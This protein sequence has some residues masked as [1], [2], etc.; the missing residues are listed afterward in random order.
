M[1]S[2]AYVWRRVDVDGLVFVRLDHDDSSVSVEGSEICVE[3][4][5]EWSARFA[6]TLDGAWRHRRT[7][8]EVI[9]GDGT[10]QIELKSD[11]RGQWTRDGRPDPT[12]AGCT[13]VDLGGNPFTN[14]FVTRRV[15]PAVGTDVEVRAAFVET[16]GLSVRPVVQRYQRLAVDRWAYSD[17]EFGR[18][19][20]ETDADGIAVH[21]EGLAERLGPRPSS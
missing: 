6:I 9:D 20:L 7:M 13:D 17:D 2:A 3:G 5:D 1:R 4:P 8:V 19:D 16:P 21:Y 18:F 10:R 12:L 11:G 15:A 14:A